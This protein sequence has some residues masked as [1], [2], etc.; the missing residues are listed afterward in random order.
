MITKGMGLTREDVYIANILKCRPPENR[1]PAA[2]RDRPLPRPTS[3]GRSRSSGP[4]SSACWARPPPQTLLETALPHGPAPRQVAP[5][6]GIPTIVTYHPS[7]LLRTPA[8]KKDAWEDLQ[9]L[10]K[11]MGLKPPARK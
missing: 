2:R 8:A 3:S 6:S 4:S 5:L 7:Y 9:M 11:A 10:M 1:D